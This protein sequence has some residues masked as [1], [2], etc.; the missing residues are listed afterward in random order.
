MGALL[1]IIFGREVGITMGINVPCVHFNFVGGANKEG[2][3]VLT[4]H[5]IVA[6]GLALKL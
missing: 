4:S 3:A 2:S 5:L 6:P 1:G